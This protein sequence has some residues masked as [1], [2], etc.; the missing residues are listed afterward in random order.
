MAYHLAPSMN[1]V[2]FPE[3]F[4]KAEKLWADLCVDLSC[5]L[6]FLRFQLH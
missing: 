6:E 5:N 4:L 2:L 1:T 3:S